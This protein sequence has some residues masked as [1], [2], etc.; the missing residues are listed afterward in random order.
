MVPFPNMDSSLSSISSQVMSGS[1][2][3]NS[4]YNMRLARG[5]IVGPLQSLIALRDVHR[6]VLFRLWAITPCKNS[7]ASSMA[8][9]A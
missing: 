6:A 9:F 5:E 2:F 4:F 3:H 8:S 7:A 1:P